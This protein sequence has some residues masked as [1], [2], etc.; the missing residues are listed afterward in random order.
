MNKRACEGSGVMK[1]DS[2][3]IRSFLDFLD[4]SAEFLDA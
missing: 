4:F 2:C 3:R 1:K